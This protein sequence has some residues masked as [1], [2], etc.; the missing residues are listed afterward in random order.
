M[1]YIMGN[2]QAWLCIP[3]HR[4]D[5]LTQGP[6]TALPALPAPPAVSAEHGHAD[7]ADE[8]STD[9]EGTD[10]PADEAPGEVQ[11]TYSHQHREHRPPQLIGPVVRTQLRSHAASSRSRRTPR[12]RP[13]CR[14]PTTSLSCRRW[15]ACTMTRCC[16]LA[17]QPDGFRKA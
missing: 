5:R 12:G 1:R 17:F 4:P 16:R 7:D 9:D 11:P 13:W 14:L 10:Q 15:N 6:S 2:G 8:H 3:Q